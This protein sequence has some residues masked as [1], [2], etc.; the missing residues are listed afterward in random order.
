MGTFRS[1]PT[2][3]CRDRQKSARSGRRASTKADAIYFLLEGIGQRLSCRPDG[4]TGAGAAPNP[5]SCVRN[6]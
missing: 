5:Y 3:A 1:W 6:Q 2:P 4:A